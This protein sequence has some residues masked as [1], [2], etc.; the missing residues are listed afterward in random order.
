MQWCRYD[1]WRPL[2][3][4]LRSASTA[5][6]ST[7]TSEAGAA[8]LVRGGGLSRS[9]RKRLS[10][11]ASRLEH[12]LLLARDDDAAHVTHFA[13]AAC[14]VVG[15]AL[16]LREEA[17]EPLKSLCVR[18]ATGRLSSSD[19]HAAFAAELPGAASSSG[20]FL[21][22]RP[23]C[24]ENRERWQQLLQRLRANLPDDAHEQRVR[25]ALECVPA[26]A[27]GSSDA[28]RWNVGS[29][30]TMLMQGAISCGSAPLQHELLRRFRRLAPPP[31]GLL[32]LLQLP[33]LRRLGAAE[34]EGAAVREA[35]LE[36]LLDACVEAARHNRAALDD[37]TASGGGEAV[38][39]GGGGGGSGDGGG[40]DGITDA[41]CLAAAALL[42]RR[43]TQRGSQHGCVLVLEPGD[44]DGD[45]DGDDDG[46]GA[47]G[48]GEAA[49]PRLL[50]VGYNHKIAV[51]TRRPRAPPRERVCHAEVHA[52]TAAIRALGEER[53]FARFGR[54]T[55]WVVELVGEV[56]YDDAQPCPNCEAMLRAVGVGRVRHTTASGH[57]HTRALGPPLRHLLAD[58]ICAPF[59]MCL[60]SSGVPSLRHVE[61]AMA[62]RS[63]AGVECRPCSEEPV[64]S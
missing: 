62:A 19:W 14:D 32:G 63:L 21:R 2:F 26:S 52:V 23:G 12:A 36:A 37:G 47:G 54:A 58:D 46:V 29:A 9:L 55:A 38:R 11:E 60:E 40:D 34:A 5:S 13:L 16:V 7:S 15:E 25:R 61:E 3:V 56:G 42:A 27:P 33:L 30:A 6:T 22:S 39:G 59:R 44:G 51:G 10:S 41:E 50:S 31:L 24:G 45:G 18:S 43:G 53:A 57:V 28:D 17:L 4:R 48:V 1:C 49:A 64:N 20:P 35:R 8:T